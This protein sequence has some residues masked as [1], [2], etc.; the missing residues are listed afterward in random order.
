LNGKH[1]IFG[2]IREK[3]RF[4]WMPKKFA[5]GLSLNNNVSQYL[6]EFCVIVRGGIKL[7]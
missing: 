1:G 2:F 4:L 7:N 3:I 6:L 5:V